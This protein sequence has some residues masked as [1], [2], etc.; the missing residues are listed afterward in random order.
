MATRQKPPF[1][2]D[3]VGSLLRTT[4]VHDARAKH[5]AG[6]LSAAALKEIEDAAII[7]MIERQEAIGLKAITDGEMRRAV[8]ST[9]FLQRLGGVRAEPV[10]V[11]A[12][13]T[14]PAHQMKVPKIVGKL[15]FVGHPMIEHFK[16]VHDHTSATAKM[17]IPSP[18]MLTSTMRDWRTVVDQSIYPTLRDVFVDLGLTYRKAIRAFA[19][20]GCR[21]LALDDCSFAFICDPKVRAQLEARGDNPDEMVEAWV[22]LVNS[23]LTDKPEGMVISTH[24]CRGN[25]R[26]TWFSQGGYEPVAEALLGGINFDSYFLEYDS[27]RAGGFEPLRFLPKHGDKTVVLGLITTKQSALENKDEIK[28]RIDQASAFVDLDRLCL[29]PQCGFASTEEGNTLAEDQQ[30]AKLSEV[31]EIADEVWGRA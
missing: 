6:Q 22:D 17:T 8:W 2:A 28:R 21:Y 15:D 7:R 11:E 29:S 27:D 31:V 26:N 13:S 25:Y 5:V 23:A 19:D 30:W 10:M 12:T 1:R 3:Q 16:F 20:A 18:T 4:E 9:D 14:V 24:V